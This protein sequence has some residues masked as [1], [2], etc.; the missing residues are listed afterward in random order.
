MYTDSCNILDSV[1]YYF[2]Y[3]TNDKYL[4][5]PSSSI[6]YLDENN[7]IAISPS[8]KKKVKTILIEA[9]LLNSFGFISFHDGVLPDPKEY[10]WWLSENE[11]VLNF[12]TTGNL[13]SNKTKLT[14]QDILISKAEKEKV[15]NHVIEN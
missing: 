9:N 2:Q 3:F 11:D 1:I 10:G 6:F 13:I 14:I 7:R 4:T 5:E 15:M 12:I 8:F